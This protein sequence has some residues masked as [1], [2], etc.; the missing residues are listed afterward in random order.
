LTDLHRAVVM[1][2]HGAYLTEKANGGEGW[3]GHCAKCGKL[4]WLSVCHIEPKGRVPSLRY[5]PDNAW[6]GCYYC[7]IHWWHKAPREAEAWIT[8]RMGEV[9][10]ERLALRAMTTCK[11]DYQA[12]RLFLEQEKERLTG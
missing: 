4:R 2:R 7:H 3:M 12:T 10:R 6:A 8:E 1:I 11:V 5:D 9:A